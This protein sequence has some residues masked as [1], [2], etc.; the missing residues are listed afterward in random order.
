MEN[1]VTKKFP[2]NDTTRANKLLELIHIDIVG[3]LPPSIA[4]SKYFIYSLM[5]SQDLHIYSF[6]N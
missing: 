6:L 4:G 3:P 2:K 5:I 1:K